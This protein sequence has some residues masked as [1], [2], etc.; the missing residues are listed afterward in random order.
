MGASTERPRAS[1]S[2]SPTSCGRPATRRRCGRWRPPASWAAMTPSSS[3]APSTPTAGPG[4]LPNSSNDIARCWP[5]DRCGCSAAARSAPWPPATSRPSPRASPPSAVPSARRTIGCSSAPGTAPSWTP[6][7]SGS[8]SGSSP[9]GC[10]KVTSV[11]GP[12]SGRGPTVSPASWL[13]GQPAAEGAE[14]AEGG[15]DGRARSHATPLCP[16]G[17]R[18]QAPGQPAHGP[19]GR[20]HPHRGGSAQRPSD[21]HPRPAIHLPGGSLPGRGRRP[22]PVGPQPAGRR[23][24]GAA[25]GP[26]PGGLPR[27]RGARRGARPG[28]GRLPRAHG[29]AR[30]EVLRGA[31]RSGRP[32]RVPH[33]ADGPGRPGLRRTRR[34][35]MVEHPGQPATITPGTGNGPT[36][37]S[38]LLIDQFLP[39]SDVTV[40]HAAVFRAPPEVCYRTARG[41]DLLRHPIMRTLLGLRSLPP[42]LADRLA[43]HRDTSAQRPLGPPPTFRLDDMVRPPL[44]WLLLGEQPGVE[45]VLGQIGRPW[46]P[47]GAS[48]GPPVAKAAFA[49]FD[50]PGFAKIAFSLRVDPYGTTSSILTMETRVA[51]T[52]PESRRRFTRYWALVGPFVRLIDR[53]TLRLLAA[54]LRRPKDHGNTTRHGRGQGRRERRR[55]RTTGRV[56]RHPMVERI[57]TRIEH[58]VDTRSA[59]LGAGLLRL[60]KGRIARLWRRRVLVLT[61]RGR[62]SGK[63]RT[64]PLQYFP[65]GEAM[66]VVAANSGLPSP[67]GW[68]FNLTA[69]PRARVE[70]GGR[71]LAG[72][73]EW[74]SAE[75]AAAFWP[76]VLQVAP[77]YARYPRRTSRRIPLLRLVP[78][79]PAT[80]SDTTS[81]SVGQHPPRPGADPTS[82]ER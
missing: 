35:V 46:K 24:G 36:R 80:A 16:F 30:P 26:R 44:D 45:L 68:Y 51:L 21:Q 3:A 15:S 57:K 61:T 62:K 38:K 67:P 13:T 64:V 8:S 43:R 9:S 37:A 5:A 52:D 69:D 14:A 25:T 39:R 42:R 66:V 74:L 82:G 32:S 41:I 56:A 27:G 11:T 33:R 10:P 79:T 31:P 29:L 70:I 17:V 18:H 28:G 65:D 55:M 48:S 71:R 81:R 49:A 47:V 40:V 22:D 53:M 78:A 34:S 50:Q 20:S 60:T 54:E 59:R 6:P 19:A 7:S 23:P 2:A 58:L 76:R 75:E 1:P 4:R 12:P 77:D 73:A 63:Q 72:V